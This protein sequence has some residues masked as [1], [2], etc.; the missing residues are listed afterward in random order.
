MNEWPQPEKNHLEV[1]ELKRL[2]SLILTH[3]QYRDHPFA[4]DPDARSYV[5]E[6]TNGAKHLEFFGASHLYDPRDPQFEEIASRFET[7]R[8]DIVYVEGL[9]RINAQKE[10]VREQAV[11]VSQEEARS[12][13]ENYFLLKLAIDAGV[14]FESP[15]PS[16]KEELKLLQSLGYSKRDIFMFYAYRQISG[17]QQRAKEDRSDSACIDYLKDNFGRFRD[18]SGWSADELAGFEKQLANELELHA[19]GKYREQVDPIPWEGR[20]GTVINDI[21]QASSQYR[22]EYILGRIA[23]GMKEHDHLFAVY[24]SAH[25]VQLEPALR[26]LISASK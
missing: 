14:D 17:Y 2:K 12:R 15:E 24:G 8:P 3:E 21:S 7:N 19:E 20:D 11:K 23:D 16:F 1:T 18:E 26:Q 22:N 4:S 10:S 13:G 25:A 6:V 5:V 9:E